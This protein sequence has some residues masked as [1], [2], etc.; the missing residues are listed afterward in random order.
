MFAT[1]A[2]DFTSQLA[3]LR[4]ASYE[5]IFPEEITSTIAESTNGQSPRI[6]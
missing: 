3:Q 5:Q 1:D 4:A 2:Q 6:I